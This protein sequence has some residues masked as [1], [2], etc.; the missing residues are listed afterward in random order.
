MSS[1]SRASPD[2]GNTRDL[3]LLAVHI[4]FGLLLLGL[5]FLFH[6]RI[7]G[8]SADES[9]ALGFLMFFGLGLPLLIIA[10]VTCAASVFA[11]GRY[12]GLL[13]ISLFA[14]LVLAVLNVWT[15]IV[16]SLAYLA[17]GLW[18]LV[19]SLKR[20]APPRPEQAK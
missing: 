12:L 1:T 14:T 8:F 9:A 6:G 7:P 3:V 5:S 17:F 18:T 10:V 15:G 13:A 4:A 11:G 20:P 19:Q 16:A 2:S